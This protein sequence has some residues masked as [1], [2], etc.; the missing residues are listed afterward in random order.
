MNRLTLIAATLFAGL[1]PVLS[2]AP[3]FQIFPN[4]VQNQPLPNTISGSNGDT[5]GIG[6]VLENNY[7]PGDPEQP[8]LLL[9]N[10]TFSS[11][12]GIGP[13]N[14]IVPGTNVYLSRDL[15]DFNVQLN[16]PAFAIA[17][18]TTL[19]RNWDFLLST[20]LAEF[21]FPSIN[22][23]FPNVDILVT[24]SYSLYDIDPNDP[25]TSYI[26]DSQST[27]TL[28]FVHLAPTADPVPEPATFL[29]VPG[30]LAAVVFFRRHRAK[31]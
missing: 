7:A 26:S 23:P 15:I 14:G 12:T 30:A 19:S 29:L 9:N 31:R 8:W 10:V 20:G 17:P 4:N 11:V 22:I 3:V 24:L 2:A 21:V 13:V 28:R 16:D 5:I 27:A 25:L 1:L 18:N 6:F